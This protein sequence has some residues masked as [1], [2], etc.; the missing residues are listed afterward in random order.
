MMTKGRTLEKLKSEKAELNILPLT[1]VKWEDYS[2]NETA[3]AESVSVFFKQNR[4]LIVRSSSKEEDSQKRSNAGKFTTLANIE[5]VAS[6]LVIA[7]RRVFDSYISPENEEVLIQPM[8]T[9]VIR[10]GVVFTKDINTG[11]D[12]YTINYYEGSDTAAVTGGTTKDLH[13]FVCYG[14]S[15]VDIKVEWIKKLIASCDIVVGCLKNNAMDIE[16]AQTGSGEI[17]IL[18]ARPIVG[19]DYTANKDELSDALERIYKKVQ[20]L[21]APHPFLLGDTTCFGVM[22]DWNPAEILGARPKKLAISLYKELITDSIWAH[23]RKNYGYRD[24]TMHPLM[25]SFCGVP[26]IDTRISFNSFIPAKLNEKIAEKLV[27]YYLDMLSSYP[28]YH[29]KIEFEIVF[30]CFYFGLGKRL[31]DLLNYG[32]NENEIKRIEY[33]LLDLTNDI[34]NPDRGLYKN[35]LDKIKKLEE[36]YST[37]RSSNISLVDEIYWLIEE[38]KEYGTLPFAGIARAG[39]IAV[40]FLQSLVD[41]EIITRDERDVYWNSLNTVNRQMKNDLYRY[42]GGEMSKESFLANYGHIRPGTYDILSQR[43]DEAF[44]EYFQEEHREPQIECLNHVFSFSNEQKERIQRELD[45]NGLNVNADGLLEFIK[46]AIEGRERLKFVFTRCV[47]RILQLIGRLG[48]RANICKEDMAHLDIGIV[49]Q[50]YSDLDSGSISDMLRENIARNKQQYN[51]AV[52][53][54]LPSII[55]HPEDVYCFHL[56]DEEA[57]YITQKSVKGRVYVFDEKKDG[58]EKMC[59]KIV[60]IRSADPG[61]DFIFSK[62]I[63]GLITQFGGAN[64][65]MAIRCAEMGI[66]AVIGIG[67]GRYNEWSKWDMIEVDCLRRQVIRI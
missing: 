56:M 32:F 25:V 43:Y 12:Y 8:L 65:H 67:E 19:I 6:K 49:K 54:K 23:Q 27:H 61:Y 13:T 7:I 37:I 22:P 66:P 2:T 44:D 17:F 26:Y 38:C 39:F 10:S 50:L 51:K 15:T 42:Y 3:V 20:K 5:N 30:S 34:I 16:F 31:K 36:N 18:Q 59:G 24:L 4:K 33:A 52:Q 45:E 11:A 14:N 53:I 35:D 47:S 64:S 48:E 40:Q 63:S 57:N 58:P 1:I 29:D 46:E 55:V 21:S 41:C 62:G 9:D 28:K 60:F